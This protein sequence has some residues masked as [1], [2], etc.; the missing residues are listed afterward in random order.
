MRRRPKGDAN[1]KAIVEALR[2]RG[3][4]VADL[5]GCGGGIP[6]LY[7]SRAGQP[8]FLVEVKNPAGKNKLTED[9]RAF[10]DRGWLV[11]IVR[12]VDEALAL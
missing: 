1:A 7:V 4:L 12:N 6:D 11:K 3:W 5:G 9:Q 10:L 8:G 2:V